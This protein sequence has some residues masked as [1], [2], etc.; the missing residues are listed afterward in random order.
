MVGEVGS[1]HF[2]KQVTSDSAQ[3]EDRE[4]CAI[5]VPSFFKEN[6]FLKLLQIHSKLESSYRAVLCAFCPV[7]PLIADCGI[8]TRKWTLVPPPGLIQSPLVV[9]ACACVHVCAR[10]CVCMHTCVFLC[11]FL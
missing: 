9:P 11:R 6:L 5:G 2:H 7:P 4:D 1:E 8:K 10:A 3:V